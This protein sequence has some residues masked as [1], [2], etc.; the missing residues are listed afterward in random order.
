MALFVISKQMWGHCLLPKCSAVGTWP[1][2]E[3]HLTVTMTLS[4]WKQ[5]IISN[6]R[7]S[8]ALMRIGKSNYLHQQEPHLIGT[9]LQWAEGYLQC[10]YLQEYPAFHTPSFQ[11]LMESPFT[12]TDCAVTMVSDCG[13]TSKNS[14][15]LPILW[16]KPIHLYHVKLLCKHDPIVPDSPRFILLLLTGHGS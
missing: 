15:G 9:H 3:K 8:L 16:W 12:P 10:F 5:I 14:D 7:P 2:H 6:V 13:V 11:R 1:A 4:H